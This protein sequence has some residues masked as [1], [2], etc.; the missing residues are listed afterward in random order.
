MGLPSANSHEEFN[1]LHFDCFKHIELLECE[2]IIRQLK[3]HDLEIT[4]I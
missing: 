1:E 4:K 3:E 2:Q